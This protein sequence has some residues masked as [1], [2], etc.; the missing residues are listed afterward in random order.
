MRLLIHSVTH[1]GFLCDVKEKQDSDRIL[2]PNVTD[3]KV[4]QL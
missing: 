1:L 4:A 3:F 2:V